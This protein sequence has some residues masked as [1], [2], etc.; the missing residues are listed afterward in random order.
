MLRLS[1]SSATGGKDRK[2]TFFVAVTVNW[3]ALGSPLWDFE[4]SKDDA[5][6]GE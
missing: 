4:N 1:P 6:A 2:L 3:I 5:K